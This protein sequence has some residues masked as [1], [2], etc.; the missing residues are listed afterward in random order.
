M[1]KGYVRKKS[2]LGK[3]IWK[4][5]GEKWIWGISGMENFWGGNETPRYKMG[6]EK[7]IWFN[8]EDK[9]MVTIL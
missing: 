6:Q 9:E 3:E 7:I 8:L 5:K 1:Y 2:E 4:G